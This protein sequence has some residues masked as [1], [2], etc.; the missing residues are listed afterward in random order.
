[1]A[2]LYV[3]VSNKGNFVCSNP[4]IKNGFCSVHQNNANLLSSYCTAA[5]QNFFK[6]NQLDIFDRYLN[7]DE[8]SSKVLNDTFIWLMNR[9]DVSNEVIVKIVNHP[10]FRPELF[11]YNIFFQEK[12]SYKANHIQAGFSAYFYKRW[13][14]KIAILAFNDEMID[15]ANFINN[16][17]PITIDT[18]YY[19]TKYFLH[20]VLYPK[21]EFTC[22]RILK[23]EFDPNIILEVRE[24]NIRDTVFIFDGIY[25]ISSIDYNFI[26][27]QIDNKI[28]DL[29]DNDLLLLLQNSEG[30]LSVR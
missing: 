11:N 19:Y 13:L 10:K 23:I 30:I 5:C 22:D 4:V 7:L 2:C 28:L 21:T 25:L 6:Y 27:K 16:Y 29:D 20:P 14:V 18:P 12:T 15:C 24:S 3:L 9:T 17:F 8:I 1:M 26:G